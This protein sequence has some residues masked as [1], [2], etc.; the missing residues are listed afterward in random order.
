MKMNKLFKAIT[1]HKGDLLSLKYVRVDHEAAGATDSKR[2]LIVEEQFSNTPLLVSVGTKL[3][4]LVPAEPNQPYGPY[5]CQKDG[6]LTQGGMAIKYPDYK[7][8]IPNTTDME[9]HEVRTNCPMELIA[10][11]NRLGVV[12]DVTFILDLFKESIS[13]VF[14][15]Y[16][17]EADRPFMLESTT[18]EGVAYK[19]ILLPY[20][21]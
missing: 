9:Q 6:F 13:E 7:R 15:V 17:R 8:I 3:P 21:V 19:Y 11:I 5:M 1:S 16:Y 20:F 4:V 10:F 18:S 12:F 2:M 14:N